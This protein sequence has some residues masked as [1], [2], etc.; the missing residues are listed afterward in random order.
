MSRIK[1]SPQTE[2][3][4]KYEIFSEKKK[5][6]QDYINE[7][8]IIYGNYIEIPNDIKNFID[9]EFTILGRFA[10]KINMQ[11]IEKDI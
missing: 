10:Q 1:L 3:L 8:V 4:A 7:Q 2:A 5:E 9:K 11:I 6:L